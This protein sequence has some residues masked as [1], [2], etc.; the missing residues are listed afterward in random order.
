MY[1][2]TSEESRDTCSMYF[3]LYGGFYDSGDVYI[4]LCILCV[5]QIELCNILVTSFTM[6]THINVHPFLEGL[7]RGKKISTNLAFGKCF[8]DISVTQN[9]PECNQPFLRCQLGLAHTAH[10]AKF[11]G[12]F[13]LCTTGPHKWLVVKFHSGQF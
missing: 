7:L 6:R 12:L 1:V 13:C 11:G 3:R 5:S 9:C 2:L 4:Q 8:G 10:S